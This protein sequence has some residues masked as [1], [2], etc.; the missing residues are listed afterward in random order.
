MEQWKT[1]IAGVWLLILAFEDWRHKSVNIVI[2]LSGGL[3]LMVLSAVGVIMTS[4]PV[5][6][7]IAGVLP[8]AFL[9]L[10][11]MVKEKT[12]GS[13]DGVAI[14]FLGITFG[15]WECMNLLL[16]SLGITCLLTAPF[17][18]FGK[19]KKEDRLPFLPFL[20]GGFLLR[21]VL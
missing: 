3:M 13:A 14:S 4:Q 15:F 20:F 1:I 11:S 12:I 16:C 17:L 10:I 2:L 6:K 8:G 19:L 9:L 21:G 18:L 7:W 5:W